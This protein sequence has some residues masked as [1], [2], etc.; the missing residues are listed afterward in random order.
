MTAVVVVVVVTLKNWVLLAG[1][2]VVVDLV[3]ERVVVE[4]VVHVKKM[5]VF[6]ALDV[7]VEQ[8]APQP[9]QHVVVDF[10][11][12]QRMIDQVVVGVVV[13]PVP[14]GVDIPVV[15]FQVSSFVDSILV[16][17][18]AVHTFDVHTFQDVLVGFHPHRVELDNHLAYHLGVG[19]MAFVVGDTLTSHAEVD[20]F[21]WVE[22][23]QVDLSKH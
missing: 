7:P 14:V 6:S 4:V 11:K 2:A 16:V 22:V 10:A 8:L 13:D 23:D 3:E 9:L 1:M 19:D 17:V 12:I 5:A 15:A 20:T 18:L 21:P